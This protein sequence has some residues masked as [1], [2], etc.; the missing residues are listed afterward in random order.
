[1]SDPLQD[2]I[3]LML[4]R[5]DA[6]AKT[7]AEVAQERTGHPEAAKLLLAS[8]T[9]R[10]TLRIQSALEAMSSED[11]RIAGLFDTVTADFEKDVENLDAL[12][13]QRK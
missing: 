7:T 1:M 4:A 3:D 2:A 12:V 9:H 10:A 6:F 13:G 5:E 11:K 8:L